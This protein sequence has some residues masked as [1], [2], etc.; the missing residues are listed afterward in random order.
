MTLTQTPARL[1]RAREL[2]DEMIAFRRDLHRHPELSFQEVRTGE[3]VAAHL[4]ALGY[5]VRHPVARTGVVADL[6]R[7]SGP[8][9][10]VRADMDALPILE[11]TGLEFASQNAGVMHAC[12]HDAHTAM[13]MGAARLL[14]ESDFAG[15]VRLIAQPAEEGPGDDPEGYSGGYRMVEAGALEGVHAALAL[16]VQPFLPV[17]RIDVQA[18]PRM[19]SADSFRL[20]V[21]GVSAHGAQPQHGVDALLAAA[22]IVMAAQGIV[23]R[24]LSPLEAGV[25]TFGAIQGGTKENIIADEVV[26]RGTVRALSAPV[27][28]RLLTRLRTV[29]SATAEAYGASAELSFEPGYPVT[30]NHPGAT[31][32]LQNTVRSLLG[33]DALAYPE[34]TLGAEDFSFMLQRVP[35][36]YAMLGAAPEGEVIGVH[37]PRFR[38]SEQALPIGAAYLAQG[39]LDLLA[40]VRTAEL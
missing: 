40:A 1:A 11:E 6:H 22:A 2:A 20:V 21:R 29:V 37:H 27:R 15:T 16:H 10:A 31:R 28:E 24:N 32:V 9:V 34:P 30:E 36:A 4:R 19:A 8:T 17:G 13:L 23:A 25:V 5:S 33:E 12:G 38:L 7:G 3:R 14:A 26:L 18:G 39:A 35:G